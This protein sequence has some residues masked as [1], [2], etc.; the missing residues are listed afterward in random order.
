MGIGLLPLL[1]ILVPAVELWLLIELGA[2]MGGL[3]T[4]GLIVL[5]GTVGAALARHAGLGVLRQIQAET[6]RG[7][8]PAAALFDGVMVLIS[9]ALLITP[10]VLTDLVGFALL[11][12]RVRRFLRD[13]LMRWAGQRIQMGHASFGVS[14][15]GSVP[16]SG[17]GHEDEVINVTAE[18]SDDDSGHAGPD[19]RKTDGEA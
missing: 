19:P 4:V 18:R 17:P 9:G 16:R 2:R 12:P 15:F 8:I 5:T 10:G 11:V 13:R 1:F 7:Q 14:T 3:A 6:A